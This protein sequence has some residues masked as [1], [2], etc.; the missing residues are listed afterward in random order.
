MGGMFAQLDWEEGVLVDTSF[1]SIIYHVNEMCVLVSLSKT[2]L[3]NRLLLLS[4]TS[5]LNPRLGSYPSIFVFLV[6]FSVVYG[7][8][9]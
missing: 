2:K 7:R 6:F 8:V 5:R 9:D 3:Q 4:R 1:V